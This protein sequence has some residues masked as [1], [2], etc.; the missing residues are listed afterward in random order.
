MYTAVPREP[1]TASSPTSTTVDLPAVVPS[2]P[3]RPHFAS[4]PGLRYLVGGTVLLALALYALRNREDVSQW[5]SV[6]QEKVVSQGRIKQ[7]IG[8][9]RTATLGARVQ[10]ACG[11]TDEGATYWLEVVA[12]ELKDAVC[13]GD[14]RLSREEREVMVDSAIRQCGTWCIWDLSAPSI[15]RGWRI[16][17]GC[18]VPFIAPHDCE[19][20]WWQRPNDGE[21]PMLPERQGGAWRAPKEVPGANE[22][23]K[24]EDDAEM[25]GGEK[26]HHKKH[27]GRG[28]KRKGAA[29][30]PPAHD[31]TA[32][33]VGI[34]A[35]LV[36]AVV[37]VVAYWWFEVRDPSASSTGSSSSSAAG[38]SA[39]GAGGSS[40]QA[41]S[42]ASS[43]GSAGAGASSAKTSAGGSAS[44]TG[45][46][47]GASATSG[48]SAGGTGTGTSGGAASSTA[49]AGDSTSTGGSNSGS[50][51]A[52]TSGVIAGFWENWKGK[53]VADTS[54]ASYDVAYYF[55]ATPSS[56]GSIDLLENTAG[57]AKDF[58]S[59]AKSAGCTSMLTVGGW[60]GSAPFSRLVASD[61]T[62]STFI[63]HIAQAI[64]DNGFDGVD[65]DWEYP[66]KAG[67]TED[68]D[69]ANDLTNFLTFLQALREKIGDDK[70]IAADTSA[71]PW[72]GSDGNASS[73]LSEFG[74]V[75]D[76]ILIMTY[77]ATTY[78][79]TIT[80]PNFPYSASCA[81]SNLPYA[82]PDMIQE[83][84]D[85]KFPAN[86]ILAGMTS[87]GYAWKV[88]D[89]KDGGGADGASSSSYQNGESLGD[90]AGVM[91]WDQIQANVSSGMT[92]TFDD[93]TGTA[94]A[95]NSDTQIFV[96]YD[97]E[98]AYNQKG[99]WVKDNGLKGCGIY[100]GMT[101]DNDAALAAMA[102]SIC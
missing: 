6:M 26:R 31:N 98:K 5:E 55:T 52:A 8:P 23:V 22:Q 13:E 72:I 87:Y 9:A 63:D 83:W 10:R 94:Y 64:T 7:L 97:N 17:N 102:R 20:Y 61:D 91:T 101:Q 14:G 11:E 70:Y 4:T 88:A 92:E 67:A 47:A 3:K 46:G 15:H 90:A 18:V 41:T 29:A 53:A 30:A 58:A 34:V 51:A 32:L 56:D 69:T 62:R 85:A 42:K 77:D 39:A 24:D 76:W 35:F 66:G 48:G 27:G 57:M 49:S 65:I 16:D 80:G 68:F 38:S 93:C 2:R 28:S 95:Y 50:G 59:A 54:F 1:P 79:S 36:L 40:A 75:L 37:C 100:A 73:D 71:G 33:E 44:G 12:G 84:I 19:E 86:K 99:G 45:T 74:D 96:T 43:A 60:T 25:R 21:F 81:P 82:F 78:S 89:F